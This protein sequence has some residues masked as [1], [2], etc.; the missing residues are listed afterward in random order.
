MNLAIS[1]VY[2]SKTMWFQSQLSLCSSPGRA[3][4]GIISILS[5]HKTLK[6]QS[7]GAYLNTY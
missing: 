3:A 4:Y 5:Y 6:D 2:T 1:S 7:S